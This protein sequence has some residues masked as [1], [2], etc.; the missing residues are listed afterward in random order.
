MNFAAGEV[1]GKGV[2]G[3]G[4]GEG[5]GDGGGW[6]FAGVSVSADVPTAGVDFEIDEVVR[7]V[8]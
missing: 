5:G 1:V 7:H 2:R 8:C 4:G 6:C 3:G